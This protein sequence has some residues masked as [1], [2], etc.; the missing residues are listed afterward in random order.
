MVAAHCAA[1]RYVAR[2][3]EGDLDVGSDAAHRALFANDSGDYHIVP[4]VLQ[5]HEKSVVLDITL[6]EVG[7]P[8][9]VVGL[10]GDEHEIKRFDNPLSLGQ[11]HG[12]DWYCEW[13]LAPGH[14]QSVSAHLFHVIRPHVDERDVL[15]LAGQESTDVAA[16]R[17]GAHDSDLVAH[18]APPSLRRIL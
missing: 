12:L 4:A 9:G 18:I 6:D 5:G 1:A 11:V 10:Y 2:L 16:K 7:G 17:S 13:T 8:L 15:A 3:P 14:M